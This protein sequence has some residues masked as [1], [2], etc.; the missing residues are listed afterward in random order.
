MDSGL[1][2]EELQGFPGVYTKSVLR[3]IGEDGLMK[4]T[5]DVLNRTA[6]VQRMVGY[7]DGS[8]VMIFSSRGYGEVIQDKRGSNGMNY[9]LIFYVPEKEKT[10]A[11]LTHEEQVEVWGDAWDQLA[12]WLQE[13][14]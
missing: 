3:A 14:K 7:C 8:Q 4:L 6:Y 10:L 9:D 5:K 1:F 13:Q 12:R 11:E 2:I